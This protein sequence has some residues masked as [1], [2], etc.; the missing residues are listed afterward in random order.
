MAARRANQQRVKLHRSYSVPE[1]ACC[2]GVHKNTIRLWQRG[3]LEPIDASR[4][5]FFQGATVRAYLAKRN[6]SRKRPSPPGMIYRFRCREPR[7]PALGMLDYFAAT[8][9]S[10]NL[11]AICEACNG[12][13]HRCIRQADLPAKMPLLEIQ[14]RQVP[15]RL[16]GGPS[17]S[18]NCDSERQ[19]T[20]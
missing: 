4:P 8:S 15:P 12:M 7:A 1:L 14:I 11:R 10:G 9:V 20:K 17:P 6:A 19:V 5:V 2:L 13:M 3:G 16:G 18:Q